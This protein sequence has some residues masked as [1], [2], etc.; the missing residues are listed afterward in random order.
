MTH[1]KAGERSTDA[2]NHAHHHHHADGHHHARS[3]GHHA[4]HEHADGD[5]E[6]HDAEGS[7]DH[8]TVVLEQR[9]LAKNDHLAAHNREAF[10]ARDILALNWLSSPGAGKT[11]LLERMIRDLGAEIAFAVIEGDEATCHDADR[12]AAS[13]CPVTQIN[14][15]TG[16]HL[17]AAMVEAGFRQLDPLAGSVVMIENVGNLVCPSLFDLGEDARIVVASVTEGEDKP[18]KYPYMFRSADL[19]LL[20]KVD[21]LPY[22]QFDV[23][24]FTSYLH[25]ANPEARLMPISATRGD[26]LG[27]L[28]AWLR[29][30]IAQRRSSHGTR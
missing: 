3:H 14:T 10:T 1:L 9:V 8:A 16:C 29:Q 26:G 17:D 11:T 23:D 22:V 13:G 27:E 28:Y 4:H 5:D 24:R 7:S 15:G 12:I 19:V 2:A 6:G 21:L 25:Q 30:R 20:N 18:I